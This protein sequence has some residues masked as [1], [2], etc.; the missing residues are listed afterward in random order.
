MVAVKHRAMVCLCGD[1]SAMKK[2]GIGIIGAGGRGTGFIGKIVSSHG[3][4]APL[5][6][7]TDGVWSVAEGEAAEISR[8]ETR[9]VEVKELLNPKSALVKG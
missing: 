2:F 6:N 8:A 3:D 7:V 5:S 1:T 4:E 9:M